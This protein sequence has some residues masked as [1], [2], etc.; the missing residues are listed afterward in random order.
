MIPTF[1]VKRALKRNERNGLRTVLTLCFPAHTFS[2]ST[3]G[4]L[5]STFSCAVS[6]TSTVTS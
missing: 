2:R 4:T 3:L 6:I 5:N 1:H